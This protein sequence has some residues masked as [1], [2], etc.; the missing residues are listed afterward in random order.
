M[1]RRGAHMG[2]GVRRRMARPEVDG[3]RLRWPGAAQRF[4]LFGEVL[5]VGALMAIVCVP[6][7]TWPAAVAAGAAHLRRYLSAE[8]TPPSEFFRDALRAMP[9]ALA[10]GAATTALAA[11]IGLDLALLAGGGLPGGMPVAVIVAAIGVV[12]L[13]LAVIAASLW[14]P[15]TPWRALVQ[16]SPRV[17]RADLSGTAYTVAALG[18]AATI[19]W[20]FLPLVIPVLGLLAFALVAVGERRMLRLEAAAQAR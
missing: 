3:S 7:I 15:G 16:I 13:V 10:V 20:Q 18:L 14:S 6:V 4:A 5:W 17:A 19:V 11:V 9:G 8:A 1:S 2:R 12:A